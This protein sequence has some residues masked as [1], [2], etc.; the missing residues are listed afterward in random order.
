[1]QNQLQEVLEDLETERDTR[2]KAE[3]QKKDLNEELEALKTELE[4]SLDTTAAFQDLRVKRED[5]LKD[6]N[7]TIEKNQKTHEAQVA[8]MRTK[9]TQQMEQYNE[10]L[11]NVRKVG[12]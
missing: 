11:E 2:I 7:G 12:W 3:R 4:D 10:E 1:M 9:H 8:E 6:L 5:E